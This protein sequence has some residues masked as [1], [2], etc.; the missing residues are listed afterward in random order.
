VGGL[1]HPAAPPAPRPPPGRRHLRG[2]PA[3]AVHAE[4]PGL[5]RAGA[6]GALLHGSTAPRAVAPVGRRGEGRG[7]GSQVGHGRWR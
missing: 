3:A 7:R 5:V 4:A 2:Q 6:T 1:Q